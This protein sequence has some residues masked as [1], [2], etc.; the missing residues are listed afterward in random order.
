MKYKVAIYCHNLYAGDILWGFT[1][2]GCQ[3][4]IIAQASIEGFDAQMEKINPD[5]LILSSSMDYFQRAMLNHIGAR[6]AS[7]YKCACWDTE[8]VGQ[9]NLQMTAMEAFKPD[10]VFSICPEMLERLKSK[11]IPCQR[12]DFAYNPP[13][14]FRNQQLPMKAMRSAWLATRGYGIQTAIPRIFATAR[15]FPF[16]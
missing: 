5:L 14:I 8:G 16:C 3:A 7:G 4:Q 6:N 15:R 11:G 12:L 1:A 2:A 13:F 9:F 10:M